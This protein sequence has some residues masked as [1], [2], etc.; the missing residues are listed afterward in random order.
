MLLSSTRRAQYRLVLRLALVEVV[1]RDRH[2]RQRLRLH[3]ERLRRR[4]LLSGH[5][6]LRHGT[7]DDI[8]NRLAG[9]AVER[10]QQPGL[11]DDEER[12]NRRAAP[13]QV[14]D[15]RSRL[16]VV[17]P[18]IVVHELEMPDIPA[19]VRID[20]DH[21]R[22]EQVVAGTVDADAIV[23]RSPKRHVEN[24]ARRVK[25]HVAPYVDAGP[26]LG[27]LPAPCV[28]PEFARTRHGVERPHQ[29]ARRR[30]PRA[31]VA[32]GA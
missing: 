25:R 6:A 19:G 12:G 31:C 5:V 22:R 27:A 18:D 8:E 15:E 11:V 7:L 28:V 20:R 3:R 16:H 13:L 1:T 9:D 29:L 21:R 4:Y 17:I 10:E 32:G 26:V 30:V 23:V 14:D 24:A 2:L